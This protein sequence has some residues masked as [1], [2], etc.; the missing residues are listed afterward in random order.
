MPQQ[1][2]HKYIFLLFSFCDRELL[3]EAGKIQFAQNVAFNGQI[4]EQTWTFGAML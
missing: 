1:H 3:N 4:R 2:N